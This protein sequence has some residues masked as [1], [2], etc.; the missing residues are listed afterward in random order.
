MSLMYAEKSKRPSILYIRYS[1]SPLMLL[2]ILPM[3]HLGVCANRMV[4]CGIFREKNKRGS[5]KK[6]LGS[7]LQN[8]Y[9]KNL[10]IHYNIT[11]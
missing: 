10:I 3:K 8:I 2:D 9:F 1:K 4:R 11:L 6:K 5:F 7:T